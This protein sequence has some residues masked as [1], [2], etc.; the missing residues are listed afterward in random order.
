MNVRGTMKHLIQ[1][2]IVQ[3]HTKKV[4]LSVLMILFL[5][6]AKC[7]DDT[8]KVYY[9]DVERGGLYRKQDDEL[10]TWSMIHEKDL[11]YYS[12]SESDMEYILDKC[13]ANQP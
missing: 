13:L 1:R 10:V 5:S 6:G 8:V 7:S 9:V 12:V 3:R 2:E 11:I 4:F